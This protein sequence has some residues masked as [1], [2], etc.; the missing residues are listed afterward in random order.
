MSSLIIRRAILS[1]LRTVQELNHDLFASDGPRDQH[2]NHDWSFSDGE[3]YFKKRIESDNYICLIAEQE[4]IVVGYLAGGLLPTESWRPVKR[5]ELENMFVKENF[6]SQGIGAKLVEDFLKWSK[7]QG[8]EKALV[9]AYASN[10]EAIKFYQKMGFS[11]EST[12]LEK[13]IA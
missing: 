5:T 1:D 11:P 13:V 3:E 8:V 12:S 10:Q 6:R 4:G 9:V 7:Q 2:L